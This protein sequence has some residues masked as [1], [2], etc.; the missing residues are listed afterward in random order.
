[1]NTIS[2]YSDDLKQ[3]VVEVKENNQ[4]KVLVAYFVSTTYINKSALRSFLQEKLPDYI[5]PIF[6]VALEKL[7]LTPN[8]KVDRKALPSITGDDIIRKEYVASTNL[9]EKKLVT[10]WQE[11]LEVEKVGI[12]DDFF[13]LGGN[14]LKIVKLYELIKKNISRDIN[15]THLFSMTTIR[16]QAQHIDQY[17]PDYTKEEEIIEIDF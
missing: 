7:P 2:Q 9:T 8:G 3:V 16:L 13:E 15:V 17:S 4:E 5:V 14:S 1:E 10:I 12:T 6:Y 11:I